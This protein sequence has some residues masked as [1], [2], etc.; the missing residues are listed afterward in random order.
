MNALRCLIVSWLALVLLPSISLAQKKDPPKVVPPDEKTIDLIKHR[1]TKLQDAVAALPATVPQ[2]IVVDV[3]IYLKAAEWVMRHREWVGNDSSKWILGS[4]DVGLQ[5]AAD[6]A[7]GK[8]PWQEPKGKVVSRAYRSKVD[9]SVQPY[10]VSY[11]ADYGKDKSKKWRL[12]IVLHGRDGTICET[13][14]LSQHNGKETPKGNDFVQI[15]IY[16]RGNNAYRWAGESDVLEAIENFILVEK[17]LGR[18]SIDPKR[19]V[20]RGFSMG[21]AGT[22][23][24]GLHHPDKWCVIGPGAGFT[25]THG[26]IAKLPNRLPDY[27]EPCLRIYDA[28]DYAPNAFDVPIV[29]YSGEIDAQKAAA[30]NIEKR[31]KGLKINTMTHLIGP[32]LAHAFPAEHQKR[33]EAEYV[34]YAG[35]GKGRAAYPEQIRFT[36]YTLKYP[37]CDWIT[38]GKMEKHYEQ[39]TVDAAFKNGV[40][41]IQTKN[42]KMLEIDPGANANFDIKIDG[43]LCPKSSDFRF[44]KTD[45]KWSAAKP[46][47]FIDGKYEKLP[48]V[49]GPIDDA[50]TSAFLCVKG[51]GTPWNEAM[52]KAS[53]AQLDRFEKEWDKWMRGKLPVKADKDLTKEDLRKNLILFGDPGSNKLIAEYLKDLPLKWS[54]EQLIVGGQMYEADKYLP[55]LIHPQPGNH[56]RYIVLN[57]GHTFHDAEFKGTN[58]QLY[59]RL[60]DYAIVRPLPT[61]KDP[62]AFEIMKAGIFDEQWKISEK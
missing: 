29:A 24:L 22:W 14:F 25:T 49:Q 4:L 39:A 8:A 13:K 36:T 5:R 32:G 61:Q 42:V 1:M 51:T 17:M 26:Y 62:T 54:K 41:T 10:A 48:G 37:K 9:G 23:H 3:Q 50:F 47:A 16:G 33:A 12:D 43:Q 52:H 30:D 56:L 53:E 40:T 59:P 19:V 31:L 21:G 60:G 35:T 7:G 44:E 45:G 58:A 2:H 46:A 57:S 11:P 55:M 34:K 15:D 18:D 27:Q 38:I 20:L 6:A 28:I